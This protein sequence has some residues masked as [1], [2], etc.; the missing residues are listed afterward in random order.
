M[1]TAPSAIPVLEVDPRRNPEPDRLD[2]R[3]AQLDHHLD[4]RID[5]LLLGLDR[6]RA[7]RQLVET[8]GTV[9]QPG[10]DLRAPEVDSYDPPVGHA[11]GYPTLPDGAGR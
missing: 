2:P 4:E 1:L 9:E 11:A 6:R 10:E 5:Q 3:C 8:T 7:L